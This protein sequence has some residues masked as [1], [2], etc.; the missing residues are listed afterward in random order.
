MDPIN[1]GLRAKYIVEEDYDKANT[2]HSRLKPGYFCTNESL[3]YISNFLNI[4][5]RRSVCFFLPNVS[6]PQH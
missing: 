3:E 6:E 2:I 4:K 5:N 1:D